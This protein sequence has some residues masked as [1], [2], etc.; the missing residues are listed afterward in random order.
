MFAVSLKFRKNF[1]KSF[2]NTALSGIIYLKNFLGACQMEYI[3]T[4]LEGII[5]F[6]SPCMLPLLPVYISYFAGGADKTHRTFV[7]AVAFVGGFTAVYCLL[8]L[9]AGS[10]GALLTGYKMWVNIVSGGIIIL[11]GLGYLD[12]IRLP[13][14]KGFGGARHVSGIFSAFIFGV[15]FSISH[16]PCIGAFLGSAIMMASASGTVLKGVFLL[17]AYSVGMGIPFLVSAVLI[18]KLTVLFNTVRK[19]YRIINIICGCFLVLVGFAMMTGLME[20]LLNFMD[21]GL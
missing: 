19:H 4:F 15:V 18:D 7:R 13:Y 20:S 9:F 3:I 21:R 16:T 10:F 2:S 8:G 17:L 12:I 14:I 11:F 6:I 5:S 1:I